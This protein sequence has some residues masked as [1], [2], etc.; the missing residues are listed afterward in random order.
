MPASQ[1]SAPSSTALVANSMSAQFF[2]GAKKRGSWNWQP[3]D[4]NAKVQ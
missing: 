1:R 4:E 3:C 2:G